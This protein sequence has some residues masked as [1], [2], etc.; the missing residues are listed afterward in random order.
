M[1]FFLCV[2]CVAL[3]RV[4]HNCVVLTC[5]GLGVGVDVLLRWYCVFCCDSCCG[6][7]L[8]CIVFCCGGLCCGCCCVGLGC[9]VP[10]RVVLF[11]LP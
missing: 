9:V 7:V 3:C 6:V 4:E 11:A 10:R 1:F 2:R 8:C 5:V